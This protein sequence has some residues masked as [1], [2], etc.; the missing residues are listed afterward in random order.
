MV[1]LKL[2]IL[3]NN[4]IIIYVYFYIYVILLIYKTMIQIIVNK[5]IKL[6]IK[7]LRA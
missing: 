6:L 4:I 3:N 1:Q 7:P 2:K 5:N